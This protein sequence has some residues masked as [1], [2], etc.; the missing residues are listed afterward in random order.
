MV[1]GNDQPDPEAPGHALVTAA[2][3]RGPGPGQP[4][5]GPR[6][7]WGRGKLVTQARVTRDSATQEFIAPVPAVTRTLSRV[8]GGP[9]PSG[10]VIT[11]T[12]TKRSLAFGDH[13]EAEGRQDTVKEWQVKSRSSC[14]SVTGGLEKPQAAAGGRGGR[15]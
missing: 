9:G 2:R 5:P 7:R 15:L 12:M 6:W 13:D 4:D 8:T 11:D 14:H 1:T 10:T 3:C